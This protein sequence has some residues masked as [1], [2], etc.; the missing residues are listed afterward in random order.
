MIRRGSHGIALALLLLGTASIAGAQTTLYL[1]NSQHAF[2]TKYWQMSA[3]A[4]N[5]ADLT[6]GLF[7]AAPAQGPGTTY[8]F[9]P[10]QDH[11]GSDTQGANPQ[12]GWASASPIDG[13]IPAGD[14]AFNWQ[15][16]VTQYQAGGT[17][18]VQ[19]RVFRASTGTSGT[20][21]FSVS[22]TFNFATGTGTYSENILS[23]QTTSYTFGPNDYLVIE[24]WVNYD[25]NGDYA[26]QFEVESA[27]A[28]VRFP[29]P[30]TPETVVGDGTAK[31]PSA[32]ACPGDG[33]LFADGFDLS[34]TAGSADTISAVTVT[35]AAGTSAGVGEV[36]V[37]DGS[38]TTVLGS[39]TTP[40]GDQWTVS[41]LSLSAPSGT[42]TPYRI[43]VVPRTHAAMPA[44]PGAAYAVTASVTG[45]AHALANTVRYND[46]TDGTIT[47]DNLSPGDATWGTVTPGDGQ[48]SLSWTNPGDA[49]FADVLILRDTV[50]I[51]VAP[52]EGTTYTAGQT[53]GT[54][55]VVYVGA[56]ASF[57]DTGLVNGVGYYYKIFSRDGCGNYSVGSETGPHTPTAPV[58]G[59]TV[60]T[61][62]AAADSCSQITV[63][64]PFDGDSDGD[65]STTFERGASATGPWTAVC[66]GVTGPSPRVCVDTGLTEGTTY[67]YRVTFADPDGVS[68]TNPQVVGPVTTPACTVNDTTI[69]AN[70]AVVSACRQITVTGDFTGDEDGDGSMAVEYNT[71]NAW[72]GTTACAAVTGPS[73]RVCLVTNLTPG[74]QYWLRVTYTDP[75]GVTGTNPEVLGPYTTPACGADT[76]A[77]TI[78]FLVP[79]EGAVVGGTDVAKV[80]V[81]DEGGLA[82]GS[83]VRWRLDGGS[84]STAVT[85]S[86]N[87][88]CGP[89]CTVY[90]I[91]L[92]TTVLAGGFHRLEVEATDAAGN[93]ARA[94]R[95]FKVANAGGRPAGGGT[96]LRRTHGSQIC[97]DCHNIPTHSSQRT[98]GNYGSWAVDC[99]TCHTPHGTTNIYLIREQLRTPSSGVKTV[100]FRQDDRAGATNP[101][102]GGYLGASLTDYSDGICEVCHT[103]TNHYRND[104]SGGDH[105]HNQATRCVGCH[106]HSN[107]FA[108]GESKGRADCSVC[109]ATIWEGMT[110]AVPKTSRHALGNVREVNDS[111]QDSGVSWTAPLDT[112][113]PADRSCVNMC[114][115]DHVHNTPGSTTHEYD[116]H[117]D[118]STAA[119]RSVARDSGGLVTAGS[120]A[121]TDFDAGAGSGGMCVSCHRNAVAT[122]RPAIDAAT[123][124]ASAHNYTANAYGT[125]TYTLHDGSTFDRNCTK[126]HANRTD[127]FP[128]ASGTGLGAV[129]FS[130]YPKL[131]AG[132][133]NPAG[134]PADFI[135]YNC[136]GN[137]TKG[138]DLSGKDL[139]TVMAKTVAHPVEA[140]T[141]H[142][143]VAEQGAG[144]NDGTY[145]GASRHVSCLDCH[146]PHA[147]GPTR[148]DWSATATASRN[149][150]AADSPLKGVSG[151]SFAYAGLAN[152][153]GTTASNFTPVNEATYEYEICFKCH[154]SF[155][156]GV[157]PPNGIS[158][159]GSQANAPE[160]D[161][162]QE[163]NPNNRSFHPVVAT[164]GSGPNTTPLAAAQLKAPWNTNPGNQTMMCSDCH[165]NDDT[166]AG[167][168]QGPHGS[169]A[170]FLLRGPNTAWPNLQLN[171]Y[172]QSFCANCHVNVNN[173]HSKGDHNRTSIRCY[174]CHI[175]IPHGGKMSRL[176]G[177]RDS[178]MPPRYAYNG[179]LNTMQIQSFTKASAY[180]N[181]NKRNCQA[182]CTGNHRRAATENWN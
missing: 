85:A 44:P 115:T 99:L 21:L 57:T 125:W 32:S 182:A 91:T 58:P 104:T 24:Y 141:V 69:V 50:S 146:A 137:G 23:T 172:D 149:Q 102:S 45:I 84:W 158:A 167:A 171:Q 29:T 31:A 7:V 96:L 138:Q 88:D 177:D 59:T 178:A 46:T 117:T 15:I 79:A 154:S 1:R 162:A 4:G 11:L 166:A 103:K 175:V 62:T 43:Y 39:T 160:T 92:D 148:H 121:R 128:D 41:G 126:C 147:A 97:L 70:S 2:G 181:Y 116:V 63:Q 151:V 54:A 72:P 22:G 28:W 120:P 5:N 76:A 145:S 68:G 51:G 127:G 129:H 152:F 109:H 17:A 6:T 113:A 101:A 52:A 106:P 132:S 71:T 173:V 130:D 3:T 10:G 150:I 53:I 90:E 86:A 87:Y 119:S 61:A 133:I 49:D 163:F 100:V 180:N 73:P 179:D 26:F 35:L 77:P 67:Y 16:R 174:S 111:F 95:G 124:A 94:G 83:A 75:D 136:H 93:V 48:V 30:V 139:A 78:V 89:S 13:V 37:R 156:F 168:V 165:D 9:Y 56:G 55:T 38:G 118:A 108:A 74:T 155:A 110:G 98:G 140:D 143:T 60:G 142:D 36:Q 122:G 107:G 25:N 64:A 82:G 8:L 47:V 157:N 159:N 176:I 19:A 161:V 169:A 20:L 164:T 80:Q 81:Y 153:Q 135:C 134:T 14:W 18:T 144:Y 66:S 27:N 114:H 112:V 34:V 123:F 170:Q 12:Y 33:A 65:G 40:S 131:L 42:P 105:T